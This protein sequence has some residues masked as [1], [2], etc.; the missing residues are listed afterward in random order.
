MHAFTQAALPEIAFGA[1]ILAQL[2]ERITAMVG[3]NASLLFVVDPILKSLGMMDRLEVQLAAHG[4][5]FSLYDGFKG[6]PKAHDVDAATALGLKSGAQ[7]VIGFGGGSALDTSKLVASTLASGKKAESY[8]LCAT[9]LPAQPL[10]LIAIPTTAGTGSEVTRTVIFTTSKGQKLWAWGDGLKPRLAMLDPELTL[11]IPGPITAATG[12]DALIHAMEAATNRNRNDAIDL[13]CHRAIKLISANL[14]TAIQEPGNITARGAMLLGSTYAGIGIDNC[15]T[16]LA[17]NISHA[18]GAIAPIM[19]G[20]ATAIA[21]YATIDWVEEGAREAFAAVANS[22]GVK[23][24]RQGFKNL[25]Q[26]SGLKLSLK[27]DGLDGSSLPQLIEKMQAPENAP[28]RNATVRQVRDEDLEP[29]ARM[30]L[31]PASA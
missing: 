2:P 6:E 31:G 23:D 25:V 30:V 29:L 8:G 15:G 10:P 24:A 19:H 13:F 27:E 11:A 14:L 7:I 4:H 21:M 28:M 17:H 18:M 16:A 12:L 1:G 5:K 20:R 26:Q 3:K 22:M 9:P